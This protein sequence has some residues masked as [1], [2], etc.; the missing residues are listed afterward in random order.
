M[1]K[2]ILLLIFSMVMF[3]F[4]FN[5]NK[6]DKTI[7]RVGSTKLTMKQLDERIETMPEAYQGYYKTEQGKKIL[8]DNLKKNYLLYE[9][10]KEQKF[11]NNKDV[12][13]Q[14]DEAKKQIMVAIFLQENIEKKVNVKNPDVKKYFKENKEEFKTDEQVKAKH[15]LVKTEEEAKEIIVKLAKGEEFVLLAKE[16]STDPSAKT[17]NGDLGWFSKGR[18]VKPF[19]NAAFDLKK[20][21]YTKNPVQTPFGWHIIL[22]EDK[23][24]AKELTFDEAKED[25]KVS[26][27]QKK[28]KELLDKILAKAEKKI[29]VEDF[30]E[31]LLLSKEAEKTEK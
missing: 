11:E 13:A 19:E 23:K 4:T 17:N 8:I 28:Q 9:Y 22:V 20:G 25:L 16:F 2:V 26:L 3:G 10:A 12:L 6:K 14:L 21:E 31:E 15:I 24:E 29:K 7:L 30:S 1:K 27:V 5:L 18:M